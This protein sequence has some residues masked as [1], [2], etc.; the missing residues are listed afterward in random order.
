ML[1]LIIL[2][3][4]SDLEGAGDLA[5]EQDALCITKGISVSL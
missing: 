4:G 5:A 1:N 2:L 3:D